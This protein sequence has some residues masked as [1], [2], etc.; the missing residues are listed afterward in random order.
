LATDIDN[1]MVTGCGGL[2]REC[3]T[4]RQS[5]AAGLVG[6]IWATRWLDLVHVGRGYC[7]YLVGPRVM[8]DCAGTASTTLLICRWCASRLL[9]Q[10]R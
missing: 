7:R 8:V 6:P 4:T 10:W 2:D 9:L 3:A 5:T 1:G